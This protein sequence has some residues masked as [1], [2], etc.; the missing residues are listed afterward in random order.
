MSGGDWQVFDEELRR[1]VRDIA[2]ELLGKPQHRSGEEWRWGRKGSLS[3]VVSGG[4]AGLW[5]DHETGDG[6]SCVELVAR[7]TGI[8]WREAVEWVSGRI[9]VNTPRGPGASF[10]REAMPLHSR[11]STIQAK[12]QDEAASEQH[13]RAEYR[14]TCIWHAAQYAPSHHPYLVSK[15]V[16]P[17]SLRLDS[18]GWLIIPLQDVDGAIHSLEFISADG[19]KRFLAGGAKRGHFAVVG[20][21][22]APICEFSDPLLICEG[23]ATGASLHLATGHPVIAAMD[24]GN[25]LPVSETLRARFPEADLVIVADNDAREGRSSNPGVEAARKAAAAVDARLAIPGVPGDAN[26]LFC[27]QGHDAVAAL[28]AAAT[29]LPRPGPT[30]PAPKLSPAEARATLAQDIARFVEDVSEYWKAV[31]DPWSAPNAEVP[32]AAPWLDFNDVPPENPPPLLGLPVDVGLGKSSATRHAIAGLLASG[33]LGGRKVVFAVPRHDL[34]EEQVQAFR[35]LGI[36]AMLW[37]GRTAA[38]PVP[39]NLERLMCLDPEATFDALFVEHPVEQSCCKVTRDGVTLL[40]PH[41][42][43]CGYQ[44]QKP[45]AGSAAV[46]VCAHDSL[47]HI[48]PEAIGAVGLLVIDEWPD[49][50]FVPGRLGDYCMFAVPS[51]AGCGAMV[52]GAGGRYPRA[53]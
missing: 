3:L 23:W 40:C 25:L 19:T 18:R 32:P 24:A 6:G 9:G 10:A 15:Q 30:F 37:K 31:D 48:K 47:F 44:R 33:V 5:F 12:R 42:T 41:Y 11:P 39:E 21:A 20:K 16:T 46:I 14:A 1:R 4:R 52:R 29:K 45:E 28:V 36:S 7:Q 50:Y 53:E 13:S 49:R 43:R 51:S 17:L 27:T 34:G 2:L 35:K 26:D 22:P 8:S 38:D